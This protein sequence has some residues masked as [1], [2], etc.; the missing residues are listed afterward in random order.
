MS[1]ITK[2][3]VVSVVGRPNVGKSSLLNAL[4]G[5]DRAI[6]DALL[7]DFFQHRAALAD[8]NALVAGLLAVDHRV[9]LHQTVLALVPALNADGGGRAY[10]EHR[11][12]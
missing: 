7:A 1:K 12:C 10:P 8:D 3:A 9:N 2:T 4:A 6:A 11:S 5:F